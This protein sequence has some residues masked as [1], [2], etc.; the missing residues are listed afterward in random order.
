MQAAEVCTPSARSIRNFETGKRRPTPPNVLT[1]R[2]ALETAGAGWG[3][4]YAGR[5]LPGRLRRRR[6]LPL[7]ARDGSSQSRLRLFGALV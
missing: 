4:A 7:L 1:I 2:R 5:R 3:P 6:E